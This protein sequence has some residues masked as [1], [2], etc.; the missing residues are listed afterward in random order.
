MTEYLILTVA[1]PLFFFGLLMVLFPGTLERLEHT[2]N[3]PVGERPVLSLRAGIP[4]EQGIEEVLNRPVLERAIYWDQWIRRQPRA[5]GALLLAAAALC[6][7][8]VAG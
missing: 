1:I 5:L 3:R 7:A 6:F 4:G 8:L 2:L